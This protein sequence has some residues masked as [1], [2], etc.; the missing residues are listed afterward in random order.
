MNR[1][2]LIDDC[3]EAK[4]LIC[5]YKAITTEIAELER[6]VEVTTELSRKAI[7]ENARTAQDQAEFNERNNGYLERQRLAHERIEE[8]EK[9][10]RRRQHKARILGTFIRSLESSPQ[11]LTEFDDKVWATSIDRVTVTE[12][13]KLIFRFMDGTE[14]E[15]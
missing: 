13:G 12:G 5:D 9:E 8:L 11:A 2:A 7:F 6:D 4:A 15:G 10:K 14:V 1:D 3:K